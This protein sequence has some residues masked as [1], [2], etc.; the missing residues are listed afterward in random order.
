M[1]LPFVEACF[2]GLALLWMLLGYAAI[3]MKLERTH[4]F[5]M[6]VA[7]LCSAIFLGCYLVYHLTSEPVYYQ[8]DWRLFYYFIL[9]THVILAA[10]TPFL[11][12]ITVY[13]ALK[14]QLDKHRW[15]A[16]LTLPIWAYVSITGIMVYYM[17]H[18]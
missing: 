3:R 5:C 1:D 11:V 16:K 14:L 7:L 13:R 8:G 2:N 6:F 10:M 17:V 9:I 4:K 18:V 12:G 15:W